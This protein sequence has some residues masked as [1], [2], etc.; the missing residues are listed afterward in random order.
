[1]LDTGKCIVEY[2]CHKVVEKIQKKVSYGSIYLQ[3]DCSQ[4]SVT[5]RGRGHNFNVNNQEIKTPS[6]STRKVA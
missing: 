5:K 6:I 2:V 4:P 1:V 3:R